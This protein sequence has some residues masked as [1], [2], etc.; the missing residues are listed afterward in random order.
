M[1]TPELAQVSTQLV[2][3]FD[4]VE[5]LAEVVGREL[6]AVMVCWPA[7]IPVVRQ[8]RGVRTNLLIAQPV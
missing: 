7:W 8:R 4:G 6:A 5:G 2:G 3:T 1:V